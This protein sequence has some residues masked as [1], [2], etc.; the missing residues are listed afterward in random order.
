VPERR[1]PTVIP[2]VRKRLGLYVVIAACAIAI[3]VVGAVV[4]SNMTREPEVATP[5][6]VPAPESAAHQANEA[7]E[8]GDVAR[9]LQILDANKADVAADP[10]AQL[11]LGHVRAARNENGLALEA[12]SL[13][14]T[15]APAVESDDRLRA[16]LRAMTAGRGDLSVVAQ[17]FDTWVGRT[18]DPDAK[19][20]LLQSAVAND[21]ARRKAMRPVIARQKLEDQVDWMSAYSLD[22]VQDEPCDARRTAVA[23]L[24]AL[25]DQRAIPAL[26]RALA[27]VKPVYT[28]VRG[29]RPIKTY[30]GPNACLVDDASAAIGYLK[31][32][33][34]K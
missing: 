11:V 10:A 16:A 18:H 14:L 30:A 17:A 13:A 33:P 25:G 22:L 5:P 29:R 34:K 2:H 28:R 32:L 15:L 3:G 6:N 1:S 31:G 8:H 20:A 23:N 27:K 21:M 4:T 24:R 7:L 9:A 26:Q 19:K 12:Y